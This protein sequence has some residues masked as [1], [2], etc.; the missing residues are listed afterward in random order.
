MPAETGVGPSASGGPIGR[1]GSAVATLALAMLAVAGNHFH[2]SLFFGVQI[3]FGSVAV[4][5]AISWIGPRAGLIVAAASGAY[6]YLLWDHPFALIIFFAEAAFVGWH[7]GYA[8][9]RAREVPDLGFSVAMYW[10]LIGIPLVLLF[11]RVAMGMV[12]DQSLVVAVKQSLNGILNAALAGLVVMVV[13]AARGRPGGLSARQVLFTLFLSVF[14]LP[15]ILVVAWENRDLKDRLELDLA[16]RLRTFGVLAIQ[17]LDPGAPA[18]STDAAEIQTH[19]RQM[20]RAFGGTLPADAELEVRPIAP[21]GDLGLIAG[22]PKTRIART[23]AED[24]M[25]LLPEDSHPSRMSLWRQARY[26]MILPIAGSTLGES[27]LIELS[28]APLVDELQR[29][30]LRLLTLLLMI[31]GIAILLADRLALL[32]V[33][34]LKQL[35]EIAA[36][37]PDRIVAGESVAIPSPGLLAEGRAL[38][39][40][41]EVMVRGLA[42]SFARIERER[43]TQLRLRSV[44]DLQAQMLAG[45]MAS[46]DDERAAAERLCALVEGLV[47]TGR[48]TLFRLEPTERL[49]RF[50]GPDLGEGEQANLE[51]ALSQRFLGGGGGG[52]RIDSDRRIF[53]LDLAGGPAGTAETDVIRREETAVWWCCPIAGHT[54][55]LAGI[56]AIGPY[57]SREPEAL[58][59][60][61]L[62]VAA[63]LAALAFDT[64]RTRRR[65]AVLIK[66]LSEAGTG[67]VVARRVAASDYRI[68]YVNQGFEPLTGYRADEVMGLNCRFLHGEDR[69]QPERLTIRAALAAGE[70]CQVTL[71]NYLK[72]GT[73]FWSAL[74]LTPLIDSKGEVT[75]YVGIQQDLTAVPDTME[76]LARSEASLREAQAIAH[77][78]S[79]D[80]DFAS[81]CL[82]WSE[83]TFRLLGYAPGAVT[84]S[85]DAFYAV[86]HPHDEAGIRAE[87]EA[88]FLR[89][90]GR[91][92]I[93]HRVLCADGTQRVLRQQG[94]AFRADDGTPLRLAGTTLD[95]TAQRAVEDALRAQEERYRL[96]VENIEDL[97]V[98]TDARGR[99]QYISPSYCKLFGR[100]E[101]ELI[102]HHFMPPVHP[103]DRESTAQAI[104]ALRKSPYTC[105]I[106][107]RAETVRGWRWLQWVNRAVLDEAGRVDSIV[108]IGRD[109]TERK[110]AESALAE[111]RRRLADIIAGTKVGTWEWDLVTNAVRLNARWAEMMGRRLEDLEPTTIETW[112]LFCHPED[113]IRAEAEIARHIGGETEQ[114]R[115]EV[116][117]LHG[118]GRWIWVQDQG[119]ISAR[120]ARGRPLRMA[121]TREDITDRKRAELELSQREALERELLELASDFVAVYDENL[122]P[123]VN[124]TLERLGCF[125][126]SDRA[127][128][129]RFDL[130]A[131]TMTN[132]HQWVAPGIK[133]MTG[134]LQQL[135]IEHLCASMQVLES[136]Q[137]AVVPCVAELPD[138]WAMEREILQFQSILSVVLVPLMKDG[139]LIGFVGFDAVQALRDWS[140]A[141]VRFLR[142]FASILVSAFER[143]RT[144]S[145]LRE[146]NLR[147]DQLAVQSRIVHWEVDAEGLYTY[148]SPAVEVV[149]GYRSEELVGRK[150]FF[151]LVPERSR[152]SVKAGVLQGFARLDRFT[153]LV[154]PIRRADG[155]TIRVLSNAAPV[156][157]RDG[158]LL[159]YQGT[160]V[161]IT[162]RHLA[163]ERL[164]QSE[165]RLS[166]I[167]EYAPIGIAIAGPNRRLRLANRM[168]G[169]FV[170]YA[171]QDLIGR[172]FDELTCP[173]DLATELGL[174][175]ELMAGKR[176]VYRMTKRYCRRDGSIAWG[177]LRVALLPGGSSERPVTLAMVEDITEFQAATE[178]KRELEAVLLRYTMHL[179]SLVD[180]ANRALSSH[181]EV[182]ALMELGCSGLGMNAAE[183]GAILSDSTYRLVARCPETEALGDWPGTDCASA[184]EMVGAEPGI[185]HVLVGSQLPD[186]AREAGYGSCVLMGLRWSGLDGAANAQMIRLWGRG[187]CAELSGPERELLRLIGQRIVA[188]QYQ[189]QLQAALISAKERETI[190][191]LASG[192]AHD[193]NNL[194]GVIDANLDYL[195]AILSGDRGDPEI[196][197]V[198]DE[199]RSALC[200]AKVIT[201]GMLSL[202]RAGGIVLDDVT[203]ET[204]IQELMTILRQILPV[205]IRVGLNIQPGLVARTNAAFLQA[206]LLNLVL[207][208]RDAMPDGGDL[209]I[210]ATAVDYDG[211]GELVAGR[212]DAGAYAQVRISDTGFGMAAGV[213]A[214]LFEPLF[215]TKAKQR[216]HGL[217]L[218]MV[219]EFVQRSGAGLALESRVGEGTTF[220]LLMPLAAVRVSRNGGGEVS[221]DGRHG[222]PL[223]VLVVDD[224][225]R[226]RESVGRLLSL[227]GMLLAFAENG[228][229][230]RAV[231]QRDPD[232][233]L[234]VSDLAMPMLDGV[235]L[236]RALLQARPD[237]PVILMT[238]QDPSLFEIGE[239]P[240]PPIVLRKPVTRS[241]L[242]AA[243]TRTGIRARV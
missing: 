82:E 86:A 39:G 135:P 168:L 128:V 81:G 189:G 96:V 225:S 36:D 99:L 7:R 69:D 70:P 30:V 51:C 22:A 4:L 10:C 53:V 211:T 148:L 184:I 214:R 194:L 62:E 207:N 45:L 127:Y 146:S 155:S 73:G 21:S 118:D 12:W 147:H 230:A 61:I 112:R 197:Q 174:F 44:R 77:L 229:E 164:E 193:F 46:G 34:P 231:L 139:R 29:V 108:G 141:E 57:R 5:L 130:V 191:H 186:G 137:A 160:D 126:R 233:D 183:I 17:D 28:A 66:A 23:A 219:Q 63:D 93:E 111:E 143:A 187:E 140:E 133:P 33:R 232:F 100:G 220:R 125:T 87:V 79:W 181:E 114:F 101:A 224:D 161:D 110:A 172:R 54:D 131:D 165:A 13:A 41:F 102:G 170:G 188:Q 78:G 38:T 88:A 67:I 151:D 121:G 134:H 182:R 9:R 200:H 50:A 68:S 138:A 210:E 80:F 195:Q 132:S 243:V 48:C 241:A 209:A 216:G 65:H 3:I 157:A 14:L 116:R 113:R 75:H 176:S 119:R 98:R 19:V 153:D 177:D 115:L 145:A 159:G 84:P 167:F 105:L 142:V 42:D 215:S 76:R 2:L 27:L 107:Q 237:L 92:S 199:T 58:M 198:I 162:E 190:G 35:V 120:D 89:P 234:V 150:Y 203:L 8:R 196:A 222:R 144:Y 238:G 239:L 20:A 117:M 49:A 227:E 171:P 236:W 103:E 212:L 31:A 94:R 16:D 37:V 72:D 15:S 158:T 55:L 71:R 106:E 52:G 223:R 175:G 124:R 173:D 136:G 11:Y 129:F 228:T 47:P 95:I 202:S 59:L 163:Q 154:N 218:F 109:I 169:E 226:V 74:N 235:D 60:E 104:L 201:S 6:T 32:L 18:T 242:R 179:E 64:L 206:A 213:L 149:W 122:D 221:V 240:H 25:I 1:T 43:D 123:L 208:A 166:A 204:T 185:P 205:K 40:A 156:F 192:V 85:L 91:L 24:L 56:V 83:E 97:V 217:G 26:R 178:R 180:L 90:D 152:D